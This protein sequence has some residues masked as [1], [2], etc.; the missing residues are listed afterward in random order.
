[1]ERAYNEKKI[2][3]ASRIKENQTITLPELRSCPAAGEPR[4]IP[5]HLR[6]M[7]HRE[8]L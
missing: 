8:T 7:E 2:L 1:M 5:D 6:L 3:V 4:S